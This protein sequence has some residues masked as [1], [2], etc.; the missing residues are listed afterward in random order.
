M[1]EGRLLT[2]NVSDSDTSVCD[3]VTETDPGDET[4]MMMVVL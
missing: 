2:V 3:S 1:T 4:E